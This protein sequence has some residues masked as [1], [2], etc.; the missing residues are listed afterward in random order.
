MI[1]LLLLVRATYIYGVVLHAHP[2]RGESHNQRKTTGGVA[3][4]KMSHVCVQQLHNVRLNGYYPGF[5]Q[6]FPGNSLKLSLKFP[7]SHKNFPR[8]CTNQYI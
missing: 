6:L 8:F 5:S 7:K 2:V 1:T 4:H 3:T